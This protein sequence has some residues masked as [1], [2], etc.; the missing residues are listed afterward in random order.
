MRNAP[1]VSYEEEWEDSLR[2]KEI[3]N[4]SGEKIPET[5]LYGAGDSGGDIEDEPEIKKTAIHQDHSG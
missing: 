1:S 4:S 2:Q 3:G 5:R